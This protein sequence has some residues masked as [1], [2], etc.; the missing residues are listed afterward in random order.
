MRHPTYLEEWKAFSDQRPYFARA[1]KNIRF[2]L[3][4]K[5]S[6]LWPSHYDYVSLPLFMP[7]RIFA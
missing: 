5:G 6:I 7:H 2:A 1:A 4:S 3:F